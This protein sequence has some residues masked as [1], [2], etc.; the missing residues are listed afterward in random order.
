[1]VN[2]QFITD[3]TINGWLNKALCNL[4]D[5]LI[6]AD[7]DFA[8][9]APTNIVTTAG[10]PSY[11]VPADFYKHRGVDR[12]LGTTRYPLEEYKQ[13]ERIGPQ[14]SSR[15]VLPRFSIRGNGTNTRIWFDPD[16]GA[17]TYELHYCTACPTLV[18]DGDTF[19]GVS[20]WEDWPILKVVISMLNAEKQDTRGIEREL[21]SVE[22]SARELAA[23]T[24]NSE[25]EVSIA[26]VRPSFRRGSRRV[27]DW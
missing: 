11:V 27:I 12:V 23:K 8:A 10:T 13:V 3:A 17:Y 16:P 1:M 14:P 18:A 4:W 2:T 6:V 15:Q 25:R 7:P 9:S 19:D 26:L 5:M 21:K 22:E 24:R 20:G